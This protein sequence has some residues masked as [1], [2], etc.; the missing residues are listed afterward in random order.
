MEIPCIAVRVCVSQHSTDSFDRK[1]VRHKGAGDNN[2]LSCVIGK[3]SLLV[4][5]K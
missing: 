5:Y 1:T 3:S 4:R 2:H